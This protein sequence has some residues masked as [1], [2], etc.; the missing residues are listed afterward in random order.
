[1]AP[2]LEKLKRITR[3]FSRN[4]KNPAYPSKQSATPS[5]QSGSTPPEP[6]LVGGWLCAEGSYRKYIEALSKT[7]PGLTTADPNNVDNPLGSGN[8]TVVL[9]EAPAGGRPNFISKK[10]DNCTQLQ[11]HFGTEPRRSGCRRIYIMEGLARDYVAT[12]GGHFYMEPT[13]W[14]RQERTCVWSTDFT[15]VSDALSQ[16]SLLNPERSFHVQ[17]CELREFNK[18]V[19]SRP[20]FCKRTGRHVGMTAPRQGA[21]TT[22]VILRRKVS[23]WSADRSEDDKGWDVV[24]LCDP[25][26]DKLKPDPKEYIIPQNK[27]PHHPKPPSEKPCATEKLEDKDKLCNTPFQG[28][29]IDFVPPAPVVDGQIPKMSQHPHHSMLRDLVYYHETNAHRLEED[30]EWEKPVTSAFFLKKIVAAHELQLTDYIKSVLPSLELKLTTGWV[31]E[32]EQWKGLQTIS[33]RCG[34]YRDDIEDTLLSLGFPLDV[35]REFKRRTWENCEI[36]YQYAYFRMKTLKERADNLM[37]SMTGLASIAGNHQNLEEAKR[38]KRLNLLALLFIP[39]AYTSSLF[40][41]Q[42][43]YAPNKPQFWVYWVCALGV[44]MFTSVVTWVLDR[45]L[46]DAAEWSLANFKIWFPWGKNDSQT[47]LNK[48]KTGIWGPTRR[49]TR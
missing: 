44:V 37:T 36:D 34:N 11:E 1:M 17:Y 21:D 49:E 8:A 47:R 16:P 18:A 43:E 46:N 45:A 41:M 29:Y 38:L 25:Q 42:D 32:K 4:G 19:E 10:F 24:I 35:P 26:L 48:T 23:W 3:E 5:L 20:F 9:L 27:G 39:L 30:K 31:E 7:N 12:I 40:S 22:T 13:F 15:P 2:T 6:E 33:R 28:G 14:L